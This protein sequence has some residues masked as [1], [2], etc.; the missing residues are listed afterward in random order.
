MLPEEMTER[1]P[2]S[3]S[4]MTTL[5]PEERIEMMARALDAVSHS[6]AGPI[7]KAMN[8]VFTMRK[9]ASTCR[10]TA[11]ALAALETEFGAVVERLEQ[12]A[13]LPRACAKPR[14]EHVGVD[15]V[16]WDAVML[17]GLE[18]RVVVAVDDTSLVVTVDGAQLARG[19][20]ELLINAAEASVASDAIDLRVRAE[21]GKLL[22]IVSDRGRGRWPRPPERSLDPLY[23][24][25]PR[26]VG[27]GL[28]LAYR[29]ATA[30]GGTLTIEPKVTGSVV[31]LSV[32]LADPFN[33]RRSP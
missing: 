8:R 31:T 27:L 11:D 32:A 29:V 16:V 22:F 25:K 9:R 33:R 28:P 1:R 13:A 5:V 24:S 3:R 15:S 17:S 23:T 2:V 26:S 10:A 19:L 4:T 14:T 6:V 7:R 21:D 30:A 18:S 20:A 12:L